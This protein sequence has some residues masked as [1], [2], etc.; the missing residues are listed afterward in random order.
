MTPAP[1]TTAPRRHG[2]PGG[3]EDDLVDAYLAGELPG[4]LRE[5][6]EYVAAPHPF[7]ESRGR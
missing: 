7:P 2:A 6:A 4:Q 1:M 5:R 3:R